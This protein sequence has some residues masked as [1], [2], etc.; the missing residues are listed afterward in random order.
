M[1][2]KERIVCALDVADTDRAV[3]LVAQLRHEVGVFKVGLEL[4]NAAGTGIFA[5]L[6]QA[7]AERF[8]YDAKLHDIPNTVAGAIRQIGRLGVWCVTLHAAGG[9]AMLKAAVKAAHEAAEET[10]IPR[11]RLLGVTL[12][13]SLSATELRNELF[14]TASV[15]EYVAHLARLAFEAGCDGVIASPQE[16]E[17]V[18]DAI[19]DPDFLILTPGVR[20]TGSDVGDQARV[21]TPDEAIQRGAD[22]LVIGR[23]IVAAADPVGAARSLAERMEIGL[24]H[25]H[26]LQVQ[27]SD[28]K[29]ALSEN[30]AS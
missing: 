14:V 7:G 27:V 11:P 26:P 10:G 13:T 28:P 17:T 8:F 21:M 15:S 24:R 29:L 2:A 18:R 1:E 5:Q 6:R 3:E 30:N 12:L 9:S 25:R 23:P 19:P 16:I 20:P 22:Y 4:V